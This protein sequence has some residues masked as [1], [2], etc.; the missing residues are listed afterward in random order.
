MASNGQANRDVRIT[1]NDHRFVPEHSQR[2]TGD[3][4]KT[5]ARS[6]TKK[7]GDPSPLS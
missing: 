1:A 5:N 4:R 7:V 3:T 2:Q 6:E